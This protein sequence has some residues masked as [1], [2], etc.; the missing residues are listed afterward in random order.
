MGSVSADDERLAT[1]T[2]G[3]SGPRV[4][5]VHGLFGQGR[6]WTTIAKALAGEGR[7]VTLVDLPNHGHSPWTDTSDYLDMAAM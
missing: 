5:F 1:R 6:N 2:I 7:R 4:G 3:T